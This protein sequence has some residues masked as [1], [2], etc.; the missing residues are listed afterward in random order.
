MCFSHPGPGIT[1]GPPLPAKQPITNFKPPAYI[2]GTCKLF[3]Y[4]II[5]ANLKN[6]VLIK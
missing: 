3:Q 5:L 1:I 2:D 6:L 4:T